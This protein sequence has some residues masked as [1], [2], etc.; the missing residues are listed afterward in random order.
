MS[1]Y[2]HLVPNAYWMMLYVFESLSEVKAYGILP[3]TTVKGRDR[4]LERFMYR[5]EDNIKMDLKGIECE[6]VDWIHLAQDG[7]Q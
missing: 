2:K 1:C 5:W 6:G 7:V 3:C 4:P